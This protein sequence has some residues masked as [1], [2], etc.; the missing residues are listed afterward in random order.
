MTATILIRQDGR[1]FYDASNGARFDFTPETVVPD[2]NIVAA[3]VARA[4]FIDWAKARGLPV[5]F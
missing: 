2:G 4:E 3:E 5:R 1:D